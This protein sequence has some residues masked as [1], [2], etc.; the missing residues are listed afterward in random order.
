MSIDMV[1]RAIATF[2]RQPFLLGLGAELIS[3]EP[4]RVVIEVAHK[5]D[6]TQ[7]H[8]FFHAGV[9][10]TL[11]DTSAGLAAL[12]VMPE[13]ADVLTAEFKINLIAPADGE[14]LRA[15]GE[16]LKN[17]RRLVIVRSVIEVID[18]SA[19]RDCAHFLGTMVPLLPRSGQ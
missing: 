14:R 15:T 9:T 17:G 10:S 16:V 12:S 19:S 8:G 2:H 5:P 13:G 1:E 3:A 7:Q 18:D 11:G 6:L 4:G